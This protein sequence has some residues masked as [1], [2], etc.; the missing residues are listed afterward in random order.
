ML[1]YIMNIDTKTNE[2]VNESRCSSNRA[3]FPWLFRHERFRWIT[4]VPSR[5]SRSSERTRDP[6]DP[7]RLSPFL[8][9]VFLYNMGPEESRHD[10]S[11][12]SSPIRSTAFQIV[13]FDR[14][15]LRR[16]RKR[17]RTR[18]A[19]RMHLPI[20]KYLFSRPRFVFL[21]FLFLHSE[22]RIDEETQRKLRFS[23]SQ[24]RFDPFTEL[25]SSAPPSRHCSLHALLT[26]L[27]FV[28]KLLSL[29]S[30]FLSSL[31][32]AERGHSTSR[33]TR[34]ST[35]KTRR[36]STQLPGLAWNFD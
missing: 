23:C 2:C 32:Q 25:A 18:L 9:R 34:S 24:K 21:F 20:E 22:R 12:E 28:L 30:F 14:F 17:T 33:F 13:R 3:S 1:V 19:Q 15:D 11:R 7:D 5:F 27:P 16:G 8:D 36:V 31:S 29:F 4:S 26:S 6:V 10:P 35:F